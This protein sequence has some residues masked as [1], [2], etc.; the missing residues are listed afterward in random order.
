ME[1]TIAGGV[2]TTIRVG[3]IDIEEVYMNMLVCLEKAKHKK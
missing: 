2:K 3:I 1:Y